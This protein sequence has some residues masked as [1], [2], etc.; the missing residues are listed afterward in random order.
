MNCPYCERG[1]PTCTESVSSTGARTRYHEVEGEGVVPCLHPVDALVR[2]LVTNHY[3]KAVGG[4]A[5]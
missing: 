4:S 3:R 5:T 1:I 2:E